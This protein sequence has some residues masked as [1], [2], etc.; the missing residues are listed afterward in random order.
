ML[1][2]HRA[3]Q[4]RVLD[5]GV[6]AVAPRGMAGAAATPTGWRRRRA[7]QPRC[8]SDTNLE[9]G[10]EVNELLAERSS[11]QQVRRHLRQAASRRS[12]DVA[13]RITASSRVT[14]ARTSCA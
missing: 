9:L 10:E 7:R 8:R 2:W 4:I 6:A 3:G 12:I 1:S 5:A 14:R 13:G 11:P